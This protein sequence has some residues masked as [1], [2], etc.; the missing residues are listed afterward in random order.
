MNAP[1]NANW[2]GKVMLVGM[3]YDPKTDYHVTDAV[4]AGC[5]ELAS[6]GY[7]PVP[8]RKR[9][10]ADVGDNRNAVF[11][12]FYMR[13]EF[14]DL[15]CYDQDVSWEPGTF[16]RL[17]SHPVDLVMGIY[18]KRAETQ[19][20]ALRT[21]PG[22]METVNPQTGK[23]HP[24]GLIK[25]AG[26]PA[27]LM[28]ISR[29]CAEKMVTAYADRW[30]ASKDIPGGK[31]WALFEFEVRNNERISED[32]NFCRMWRDI[33]GEVWADPHLKLHHHGDTAYSG[34]LIDHLRET[35]R[36]IDSS[37]IAKVETS[38]ADLLT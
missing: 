12:Q 35:D 31:A 15:I 17:V 25:I 26:G 6:C 37:A 30:Y 13:P 14:T 18:R 21:L 7:M 4:E 9:G 38:M 5:F 24:D 33:G 34:K 1:A 27:G 29:G 3:T 19:G 22:P 23:H 20:Y 32:M 11:S 10:T 28:R 2:K 8:G 36:L 16:Q